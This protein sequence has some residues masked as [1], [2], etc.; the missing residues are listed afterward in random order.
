M[1]KQPGLVRA[2]VVQM[3]V[4]LRE[5]LTLLPETEVDADRILRGEGHHERMTRIANIV[6]KE[7]GDE[8][9]GTA[10]P[11]FDATA[12]E[13]R[14]QLPKVRGERVAAVREKRGSTRGQA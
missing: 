6:L 9:E 13:V 5:R 7:I 8:R 1:L 12:R 10:D 3:L 4:Q 11:R 14:K 2:M